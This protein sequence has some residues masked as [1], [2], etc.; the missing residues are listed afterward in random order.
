MRAKERVIL[1]K[2]DATKW[3]DQAIFIVNQNL[4]ANK[5]PVDFVGEAEK[6]IYNYMARSQ[7]AAQA[8]PQTVAHGGAH[9]FGGSSS[10]GTELIESLPAV[11]VPRSS[12]AKPVVKSVRKKKT[13]A[14]FMLNWLMVLACIAI[15]MVFLYGMLR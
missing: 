12:G 7:K 5:I 4:P 2:G 9:M 10:G 1:I 3:Y 13:K 8:T 6:I 14:D 11:P 15:A